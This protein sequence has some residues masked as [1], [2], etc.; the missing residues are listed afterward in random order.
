MTVNCGFNCLG[1]LYTIFTIMPVICIIKYS[2][3]LSSDSSQSYMIYRLVT[4]SICTL[5]IWLSVCMCAPE[6][7]GTSREGD[8]LCCW[9]T[10]YRE[11]NS[12][13][14]MEEGQA[15]FAAYHNFAPG[16]NQRLNPILTQLIASTCIWLLPLAI[17]AGTFFVI[18]SSVNENNFAYYDYYY[19]LFMLIVLGISLCMWITC[20][21]ILRE[22]NRIPERPYH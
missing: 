19:S 8:F 10:E 3:M 18:P 9:N 16:R 12:L 21:L 2:E 20:S 22:N 14:Y 17:N 15:G 4:N 6:P 7:N 5:V 11:I 1:C 13:L